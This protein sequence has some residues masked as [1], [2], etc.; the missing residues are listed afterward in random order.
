MSAMDDETRQR[1]AIFEA[2]IAAYVLNSLNPEQKPELSYEAGK[3]TLLVFTHLRGE[4]PLVTGNALLTAIDPSGTSREVPAANPH[5]PE[6][7][8]DV[9]ARTYLPH[10]TG[11]DILAYCRGLADSMYSFWPTLDPERLA[12]KMKIARNDPVEHV[13]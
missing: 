13:S 2:A 12:E 1:I 10:V 4:I 8:Y 6:V 3:N 7:V 11:N 9:V 5:D